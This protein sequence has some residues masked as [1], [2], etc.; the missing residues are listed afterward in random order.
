MRLQLAF[1]NALF[2]QTN[3]QKFLYK[4]CDFSRWTHLLSP[5]I[6]CQA[7][8]KE[9][10][11]FISPVPF[12]ASQNGNQ[13]HCLCQAWG[14][15]R[16][17]LGSE[18]HRKVVADTV[19]DP[20]A[21]GYGD[22]YQWWTQQEPVSNHPW[23]RFVFGFSHV[24]T[25]GLKS[26]CKWLLHRLDFNS[27]WTHLNYFLSTLNSMGLFLQSSAENS[28]GWMSRAFWPY[29][30]VRGRNYIWTQATSV[31]MPYMKQR[32]MTLLFTKVEELR[33][34]RRLTGLTVVAI[35]EHFRLL[36]SQSSL[37]N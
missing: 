2:K 34:F 29:P 17:R 11:S 25:F 19:M 23:S 21:G 4:L 31:E 26:I 13:E 20:K 37:F 1:Q 33:S 28:G 18:S 8:V 22:V 16:K 6:K 12:L 9:G 15:W 35:L 5:G 24:L 32:Q 14:M 10:G 7:V 27:P 3:H 30:P 36:S